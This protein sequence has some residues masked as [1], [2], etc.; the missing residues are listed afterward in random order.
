MTHKLM[1]LPSKDTSRIKLLKIPEDYE[2]H[3][4]YRAATGAIARVEDNIPDYNWEDLME[5]LEDM[6][7]E[8]IEF[9]LGPEI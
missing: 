6:G 5:E 2:V 1:I 9:V 4:V 8:D 7:F 3:E